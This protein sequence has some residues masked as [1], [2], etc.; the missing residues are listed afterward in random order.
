VLDIDLLLSIT[1]QAGA[2]ILSIYN[3]EDRGVE[4]KSDNS[5]ITRADKLAHD[6]IQ[7]GLA[8]YGFPIL[9]EEGSHSTYLARKNWKTYWLVD[10]LDGTKEFIKKNGE[11]TVNIALVEDGKPTFGIVYAPVG[12]ELYFGGKYLK[13]KMITSHSQINLPDAR[14]TSLDAVID[15]SNLNVFASRTHRNKETANYLATLNQPRLKAMGSSLKFM[16]IAEGKAD[17]YP[18]FA[19]TMEWDTAASHAILNSLGHK[20]LQLDSSEELVY[21]KENLQNPYFICY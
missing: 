20:I 7:K 21:N 3:L 2:A 14:F 9:S 8:S 12:D 18:R 5:P 4:L 15:A 6:I 17:L 1:R 19:P 10:P 11:F 16:K 13:A